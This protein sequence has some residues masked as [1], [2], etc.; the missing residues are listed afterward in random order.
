MKKLSK[1]ILI[2]I[3]LTFILLLFFNVKVEAKTVSQLQAEFPTGSKF[4][5]FVYSYQVG[6]HIRNINAVDCAAFASRMYYEYYGLY[7]EQYEEAYGIPRITDKD[8]ANPQPGDIVRYSNHSV[9]I[10]ERNGDVFKVAEANYDKEHTV[11][12]Y[13]TKT[14]AQ[15]KGGFE[16]IF[17]A[18]YV[19]KNESVPPTLNSVNVLKNATATS[20]TVSANITDND[21]IALVKFAVR[22]T[23]ENG[24]IYKEFTKTSNNIYNYTVKKSEHNQKTGMYKVEIYAW[25]KAGNSIEYKDLA[26]IPMGS[27]LATNLGNFKGRIVNKADTNLLITI[28]GFKSGDNVSL[29]TK[30]LDNRNQIWCFEK[31]DNDTYKITNLA[32]GLALDVSGG[33]NVNRT[34]IGLYTPNNTDAQKYCIMNFNNGYRLVPVFSSD[35]K[36]VTLYGGLKAGSN[37]ELH[38]AYNTSNPAQTFIIEKV[39]DSI[40]LNKT[41]DSIYVGN[42]TTLSATITPNDVATKEVAWTS[43]NPAVAQVDENG[44]VTAKCEGTATITATTQDGTNLSKTCTITVIDDTYD[45]NAYLV[46]NKYTYQFNN[47][48]EQ[49]KLE[50]KL[51][52]GKLTGITWE[53]D[54][55]N[56]AQVDT[57]GLVTAKEGGF[58]NI[59]AKS[60]KYGDIECLVYVSVPVELS[61]GEKAYV[62]DVDGNGVFDIND[63][64]LILEWFKYGYKTPDYKLIAD[65]DN[66]GVIDANDG[67]VMQ[68]VYSYEAF[69]PGNL[70]TIREIKLSQEKLELEIGK[71]AILTANVIA[72][73]TQQDKTITWS[74][75]NKSV[76]TVDQSGTIT[77]LKVGTAEITAKSTNGKTATCTLTVKEKEPE[78]I[79]GDVTGDGKVT[80]SD[81]TK[82]IRYIKGSKI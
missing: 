65:I 62:G 57:N 36:A 73:N 6:N 23:G 34:N 14:L 60:K 71:T 20:F 10:L 33:K 32:T 80:A 45:P 27:T 68:L 13:S 41:Q 5:K 66:N 47:K 49:V 12:W 19:L 22:D 53:S 43:S 70:A 30:K 8:S 40:T 9:W 25:D 79:L 28:D 3:I 21:E 82:I 37:I 7:P 39:A 46:L 77:A 54:N 44:V 63:K 51:S 55:T 2:L 67:N 42:T 17:K 15:F 4:Y 35:W 59:I 16:F 38:E 76:A 11:M 58:A 61:D 18:P 52:T 56:V 69:K 81:Y 24:Y 29:Q 31:A 78:A 48:A 75:S 64:T 72:S 50:A 1:I 74:S 26:P